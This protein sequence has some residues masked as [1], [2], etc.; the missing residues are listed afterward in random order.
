MP[1]LTPRSGYAS[2]ISEPLPRLPP[3]PISDLRAARTFPASGSFTSAQAELYGALLSAQKQLVALC[4]ARSRL[5]LAQLHQ[6]SVEL[7]GKELT[8]IGFDL[9]VMGGRLT[10]LYPHF[11]GHPVGI[12]KSC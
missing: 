11:I 8:R 7:L 2:D 9:G 4:T 10:E 12:G 1:L 5:S 6:R 3:L